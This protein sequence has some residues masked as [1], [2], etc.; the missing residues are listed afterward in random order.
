MP[1]AGANG[2]ARWAS[3]DATLITRPRDCRSAGRAAAV[4]RQ[5]AI[6][7]TSSTEIARSSGARPADCGMPRQALLMSTSRPPRRSIAAARPAGRL[8]RR[9]HAALDRRLFAEVAR[10]H[11]GRL[12]ALQVEPGDVRPA[13]AQL[14]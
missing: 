4:T 12:V 2:T 8:D 13:A 5:G 14:A 11:A 3:P 7:L 9:R 10:Q 6:R 1:Y